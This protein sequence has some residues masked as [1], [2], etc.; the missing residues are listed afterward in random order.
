MMS[1]P[2]T[3]GAGVEQGILKPYTRRKVK[4][5]SRLGRVSMSTPNSINRMRGMFRT[6]SAGAS[7]AFKPRTRSTQ[8]LDGSLVVTKKDLS[9]RKGASSG[10]LPESSF[11]L[12][13]PAWVSPVQMPN[14]GSGH[15]STKRSPNP[16]WGI[17]VQMPK[18]GSGH[19]SPR[20]SSSKL[21]PISPLVS[22]QEEPLNSSRS[23]ADSLSDVLS[24]LPVSP[25]NKASSGTIAQIH[26]SPP[27]L[28][29]RDSRLRTGDKKHDSGIGN[30]SGAGSLGAGSLGAGL[31]V[32][33]ALE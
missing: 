18:R 17:P 14:G 1:T 5:T 29:N 25:T 27:T 30:S 22:P 20:V 7:P 19:T 11:K 31:F 23:S 12:P 15:T 28:K 8:S 26:T 9:P 4:S 3:T 16:G 24:V 13:T 6:P 32:D 10:R 2:N 21:P 33:G